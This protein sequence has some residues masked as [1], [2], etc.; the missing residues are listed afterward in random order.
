MA[1]LDIT[2]PLENVFLNGE[3]WEKSNGQ[4]P[5]AWK[6]I[7][8][9]MVDITDE[10]NDDKTPLD[11]VVVSSTAKNCK[12]YGSRSYTCEG[13][14][15]KFDEAILAV[16]FDNTAVTRQFRPNQKIYMYVDKIQDASDSNDKGIPNQ[17]S[18]YL[19]EVPADCYVNCKRYGVDDD[20]NLNV[21]YPEKAY[22]TVPNGV[23]I[24]GRVTVY[25]M[26]PKIEYVVDINPDKYPD[27]GIS[28]DYYYERVV[29]IGA[30]ENLLVPTLRTVTD[31]GI[32]CTNNRDGTYT[33][34]G[35]ANADRGYCV[36]EFGTVSLG[37]G[38]YKLVGDIADDMGDS[39]HFLQ[40]IESD[41]IDVH[42][43]NKQ[44]ATFNVTSD[45]NNAT[46][47]YIVANG[48]T[49]ND[50]VKPILTTNLKATYNEFVKGNGLPSAFG[51]SRYAID[52]FIPTSST[53]A[54]TN[55]PHSLGTIPKVAYLVSS[56]LWS[57]T[58]SG[59]VLM[60]GIYGK[61]SSS[62]YPQYLYSISDT[63]NYNYS[64]YLNTFTSTS[65]KINGYNGST[66]GYLVNGEK[67]YL[68]T[69][70]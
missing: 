20:G 7:S 13:D 60:G 32:I 66:L 21:Q 1:N 31:G 8:Y 6:R 42:A 46:V 4:A 30:V 39:S 19:I 67:Y 62:T 44:G 36:F 22:I 37:V 57:A 41:G 28:G 27:D 2:K 51:C 9:E 23:N 50:V 3:L 14:H 18:K 24:N 33:L 34:S 53:Y 54:Y 49:L 68:I 52:E 48:V 12:Y 16:R 15:F 5:Y 59:V 58:R 47:R 25:T 29:D 61:N 64:G 63:S 55:V 43:P 40:L 10:V 35:T 26:Q 65:L 56:V 17:T 45:V 69:M 38:Q 70:A 11:G